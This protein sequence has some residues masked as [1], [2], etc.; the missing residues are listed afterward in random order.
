MDLKRHME[1]FRTTHS[2][3]NYNTHRQLVDA[4]ISEMTNRGFV[5]TTFQTIVRQIDYLQQNVQ[6]NYYSGKTPR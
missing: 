3:L 5:L 2:N 6:S 1:T 4:E